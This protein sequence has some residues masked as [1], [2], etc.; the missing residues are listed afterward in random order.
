MPVTFSYTNAFDKRMKF[1]PVNT[2]PDEILSGRTLLNEFVVDQI[3]G[4]DVAK[5]REIWG[6]YK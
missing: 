1:V 4:K 3:Q 6:Y 5:N 2:L